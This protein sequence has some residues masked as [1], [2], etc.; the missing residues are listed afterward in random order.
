MKDAVL[1]IE[2]ARFYE[3]GGVDYKGLMRAALANL[4]RVKSQGASTITHAGG[5]QRLPV[6]GKDAAPASSTRCC[7]TFKLEHLLTKDQILEIYL[8]QIFLGNRAYG[9][10]A[11]SRSLFRQAAEGHHDRRGGDA[12]RPAEGARRQQPDQQPEPRARAPALRAST[13]CREAGFITA[14]QAEAGQEARSCSLR[15]AADP[16]ACTPSTWP[17]RCAS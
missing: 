8:N 7:S 15:D 9:F 11:A 10:A 5:A 13:A 3:H 16:T 6:L 12:G 4:G 2:D 14:E 17:R 1:A